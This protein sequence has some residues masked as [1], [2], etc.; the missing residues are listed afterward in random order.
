VLRFL[1]SLVGRGLG[2][3]AQLA[4]VFVLGRSLGAEGS[5]SIQLGITVVIIA[6]SIGRLGLE[7]TLLKLGSQHVHRQQWG[8]FW[9]VARQSLVGVFVVSAALATVVAMAAIPIA[10]WKQDP[11]FAVNLLPFCVALPF[12]SCVVLCGELLKAAD[13]PTLGSMLQPAFLPLGLIGSTGVLVACDA[14]TLPKIGMSYALTSA[15][16]L[17]TGLIVLRRC[18]PSDGAV[19]PADRN[20]LWGPSKSLVV[21]AALTNLN[22]WIPLLAL[23]IYYDPTAVGQ[24]GSATRLAQSVSLILWAFNSVI[25]ARMA[26]F[27]LDGQQ[28][29][30]QRLMNQSTLAMVIVAL[31]AVLVL[32]FAGR[33]V[34]SMAGKEFTDAAIPLAILAV[35]QLV[36]VAAGAAD[37]VLVVVGEQ[38]R[39]HRG[40]LLSA[41]INVVLSAILVPSMQLVGAAIAACCSL[42]A[43]RIYYMLQV[44]RSTGLFPGRSSVAT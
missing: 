3:A 2:A 18:I 22:N 16:A 26:R 1:G 43:E 39:L 34:M 5:G 4:L 31:P 41:T 33:W 14:V 29:Q 35:A 20:A 40:A 44:Y 10:N 15:L 17:A 27:H 9:G 23:W 12:F 37:H 42:A 25:P 21:F 32:V 19:V 24:Y 30:M 7:Y 36:V 8:A 28:H 6:S 38:K 13:W 11:A